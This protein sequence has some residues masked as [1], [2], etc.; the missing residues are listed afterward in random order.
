VQIT[1]GIFS[2]VVCITFIFIRWYSNWLFSRCS[3]QAVLTGFT[4]PSLPNTTGFL[5]Y[6]GFL[7]GDNK[8][9]SLLDCPLS[10]ST[11]VVTLDWQGTTVKGFLGEEGHS[12]ETLKFWLYFQ[13]VLSLSIDIHSCPLGPRENSL[14]GTFQLL[15]L[16]RT[17]ADRNKESLAVFI[18]ETHYA[19][20]RII[21][22][23]HS[24][25]IKT[26]RIILD[27]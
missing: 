8:E 25:S 11:C 22:L 19:S 12:L 7:T 15:Y 20:G 10:S 24:S 16:G 9:W 5:R 3:H 14:D 21:R 4:I 2:F 13:I 18:L 26:G 27:E 23:L 6:S 1:H 17:V